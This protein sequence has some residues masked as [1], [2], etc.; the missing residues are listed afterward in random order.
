MTLRRSG[1]GQASFLLHWR[2][3]ARV[4]NAG[5]LYQVMP[6]DIFQPADDNP[7][8]VPHD[9]DLWH[10]LAREF[11]EELLGAPEDYAGLGSP[12]RYEQWPF[13]RRLTQ[14]RHTGGLRVWIVG[15]GVDPLTMMTDIL[16]AAV[17]DA[18]LFDEVFAGLVAVN[19]EG[20]VITNG[21]RDRLCFRRVLGDEVRR[22]RRADAGRRCGRA[23]ARQEIQRLATWLT[24]P[25][26][27]AEPLSR[28]LW[29]SPA[30]RRP[31]RAAPIRP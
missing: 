6:V 7:A 31:G 30:R 4:T 2:D 3:P 23:Q 8:S 26:P 18:E 14:A 11:S 9:L 16:T 5:G 10:G 27:G 22:R 12:V 20:R 1:P 25:E 21:C 15:L 28:R 17:F 19:S 13:F 24:A 29:L